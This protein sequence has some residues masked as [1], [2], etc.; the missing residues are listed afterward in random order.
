MGD[1]DRGVHSEHTVERGSGRDIRYIRLGDARVVEED[2]RGAEEQI[3]IAHV[4]S[5]KLWNRR[6]VNSALVELDP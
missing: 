4:L 2:A 5:S 3:V 1:S 6:C